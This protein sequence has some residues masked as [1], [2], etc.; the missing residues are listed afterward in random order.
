MNSLKTVVS[1]GSWQSYLEALYDA[2]SYY[3]CLVNLV[4]SIVPSI[5]RY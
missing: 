4:L 3:W 2:K 5:S 1:Y